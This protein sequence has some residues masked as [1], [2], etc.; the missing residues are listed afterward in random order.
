MDTSDMLK[1]GARALID[2]LCQQLA[3]AVQVVPETKSYAYQ[4]VRDVLG[5]YSP[6]GKADQLNGTRA[7]K[8][9][10]ELV[11]ARQSRQSAMWTPERR[12]K[13]SRLAKQRAAKAKRLGLTSNRLPSKLEL[14]KAEAKAA[15]TAK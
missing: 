6:P 1:L 5:Y 7:A 9:A 2:N 13:M 10:S 3:D 12:A 8:L 15:T 14:A 11:V 4:R